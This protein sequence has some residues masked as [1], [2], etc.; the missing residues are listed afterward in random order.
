MRTETLLEARVASFL[1]RAVKKHFI[2]RPSKE[3]GEEESVYPG[4]SRL[5]RTY[6]WLVDYE[7]KR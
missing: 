3:V 5:R 1:D 2:L 6:V 7:R 4:G